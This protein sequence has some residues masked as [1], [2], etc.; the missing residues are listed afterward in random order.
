MDKI[1]FCG[2]GTLGPVT[3]LLAVLRK[4]REARPDL[5][6]AWVGTEDGP[7]GAL[8]EAEGVGFHALPRAALPRYPSKRWL[9]FPWDYLKALVAAR[10]I[11]TQEKPSLVVSAGGFMQV[12]IMR[13]A[14][15]K[16]IACAIHQLDF[17]TLLSNDLVAEKC[18]LVT[19][20]FKYP[21]PP[22]SGVA[23]KNVATPC[24]FAGRMLPSRTEAALRLGLDPQKPILFV[25]GGGTGALAIN[26][27]LSSVL[28]ELLKTAQV[29][30]LTGKGKDVGHALE[31]AGYRVHEFFDEAQMLD[32]YA[33]ADLVVSRGGFGSL[34]EMAALKKAAIVVPIP[35]NPWTKN[36]EALG[37]A[38]RLVVQTDGL[39][40]DI[41]YNVKALLNDQCGL[42]SLGAKL[43][44]ALSTDDG[45]ALAELWL[46]LIE[47]N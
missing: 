37:D 17:E 25:F 46:S 29:V 9:T 43:S 4:M 23:A 45:T 5:G 40:Q 13:E 19:T 2:G 15:K 18:R 22:F 44:E 32:A 35:R 14:S 20:S 8:V 6:F 41:L 7:E 47:R 28:D 11:L 31:H 1:L 38:V 36:A 34:S 3:P 16:G 33:A 10:K 26:Q 39:G 24:R 27:A 30:H 42:K 21:R 12:P